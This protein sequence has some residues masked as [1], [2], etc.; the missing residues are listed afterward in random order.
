MT[1]DATSLERV[2]LERVHLERVPLDR[3]TG[4]R[5]FSL[6]EVL[7][8]LLL[9]AVVLVSL[10]PLFTRSMQLNAEGSEAGRQSQLGRA[11]VEELLQL[12]FNHE[13]LEVTA[14]TERSFTEFWSTGL[15]QRL[16]DEGWRPDLPAPGAGLGLQEEALWERTVTVRQYSINAVQDTDGDGV[17]D[18]IAGLEDTDRDGV[19]DNPL[20]G[21]TLAAAVHIKELDVAV[22]SRRAETNTVTP[23]ARLR[24]QQLKS[25]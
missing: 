9:L 3:A 7:V 21:G 12:P 1:A 18:L 16:G 5:G 19:F 8:A 20:P 14:G 2:P 10:V 22:E 24:L 15:P 4:E 17:V 25:F 11:E 13:L 23:T 6:I